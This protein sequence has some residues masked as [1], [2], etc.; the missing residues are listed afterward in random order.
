VDQFNKKPAREL[1]LML[2]DQAASSFKT[3]PAVRILYITGRVHAL[4]QVIDDMIIDPSAK[5]R[6]LKRLEDIFEKSH[7]YMPAAARR[8]FEETIQNFEAE[9][10][11]E[12]SSFPQKA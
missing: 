4:L 8:Y 10:R 1:A 9:L 3:E 11:A 12:V 7:A 6:T 5:P 2:L